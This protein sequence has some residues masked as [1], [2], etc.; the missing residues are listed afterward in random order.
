[1]LSF[2]KNKRHL[3]ISEEGADN[4]LNQLRSKVHKKR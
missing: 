4:Y 1:M 3:S 2:V